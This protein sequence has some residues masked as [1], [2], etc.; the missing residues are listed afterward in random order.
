MELAAVNTPAA[1]FAAG[2]VTSL[3]CAAMC[4]PL[5]C[6]LVSGRATAPTDGVP[7]PDPQ[8][9]A[10][11]YQL[12][13]LAS[14]TALGALAGGAGAV[15]LSLLGGSALRWLPWALVAFFV[16]VALRLDRRLSRVAVL[17]R[18]QWRLRFALRGRS[19]L[20]GA[21]FVGAATPLLPCGPLYFLVALAALAGSVAR[22]AELMLAFG[23]GT[24]PLLWLAQANFGR[25]A[26]YFSPTAVARTQTTLALLTALV[27]AW[28]LRGTLGLGG[29]D[30]AALLCTVP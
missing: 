14:Y 30:A 7:S 27:L 26:K 11:A 5:G 21:A 18:W 1:A 3:H 17:A 16:A 2:L 19:R 15:P 13:R 20:A 22:G 24:L 29:P 6:A 4:G 9:L 10:T 25:L 12:S 28:R 23:L 8:T